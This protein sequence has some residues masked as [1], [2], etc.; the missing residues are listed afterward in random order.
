[1]ERYSVLRRIGTDERMINKALFKQIGM[2]FHFPMILAVIHSIFGLKASNIIFS[3]FGMS[4][5]GSSMAAVAGIV[6]VIYGTYF[7][8]TYVTSKHIIRG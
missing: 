2:F 1:M 6:L 3:V 5:L 7:L 8:V 4:G